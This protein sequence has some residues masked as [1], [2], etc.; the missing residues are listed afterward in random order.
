M[1]L[2]NLTYSSQNAL[3]PVL[4]PA[5]AVDLGIGHSSAVVAVN[6][7]SRLKNERIGSSVFSTR[8]EAT[9]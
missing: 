2:H 4:I 5:S 3:F 7:S 8:F 6:C 9:A 1:S